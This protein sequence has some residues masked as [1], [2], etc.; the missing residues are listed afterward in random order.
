MSASESQTPTIPSQL[1][2][3]RKISFESLLAG[4][5]YAA[6]FSALGYASPKIW[7]VFHGFR[8][9]DLW[10][11]HILGSINMVPTIILG[12]CAAA[13]IIGKDRITPGRFAHVINILAFLIFLFIV[14]LWVS[15]AFSPIFVM[16]EIPVANT[17]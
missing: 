1:V 2:M 11:T 12:G 5:I 13:L 10:P 4:L 9:V 16:Y 17:P 6:G 15:L 3:R 14:G 8:P 7:K